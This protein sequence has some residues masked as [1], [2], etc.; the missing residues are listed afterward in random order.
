MAYY[1]LISSLPDLNI[2]EKPPFSKDDFIQMCI[3]FIDE[4]Q[5]LLLKQ[6]IKSPYNLY[7]DDL[8][9]KK[10]NDVDTQIRNKIANYRSQSHRQNNNTFQKIHNNFNGSI[11][12][13][14]TEAFS[15]KNPLQKEKEI[16]N[17]RIQ[18]L[19][20]EMGL[21]LFSFARVILYAIKLYIV[22]KWNKMDDQIGMD[23]IEKIILK[24]TESEN[25]INF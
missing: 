25:M 21:D 6:I 15:L 8:L 2:D 20:E 13:R 12:Q 1:A 9:I 23:N 24:N 14:L 11:D 10:W 7:T 18:A 17:I 22:L 5:L 3:N 4:K 16:D 19:E